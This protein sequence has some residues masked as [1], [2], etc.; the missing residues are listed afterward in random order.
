MATQFARFWEGVPEF[1]IR[2]GC[3]VM[4]WPDGQADAMPLN[5]MRM[6][7]ARLQHTLNDHDYKRAEVIPLPKRKKGRS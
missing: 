3:V 4:T 1:A 7:S 6:L 5:K 2:D